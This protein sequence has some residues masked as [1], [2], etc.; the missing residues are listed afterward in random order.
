MGK[1]SLIPGMEAFMEDTS[2]EVDVE[3]GDGAEVVEEQTEAVEEEATVAEETTEAESDTEQAEMIFQQYDRIANY[4]DHAKK[5][6]VD[7]TFLSL[8]NSDGSLSQ[9]IGYSLPACESFD[10]TGSPMSAESQAVIAGLE[11]VFQSIWNFIKKIARKIRDFFSNVWNAIISRFGDID[12]QIGRLKVAK[13][14]RTWSND[15]AS[16]FKGDIFTSEDYKK[17]KAKLD[18]YDRNEYVAE[19]YGFLKNVAVGNVVGADRPGLPQKAYSVQTKDKGTFSDTYANGGKAKDVIKKA[20]ELIRDAKKEC[21]MS[22]VSNV[23]ETM[24]NDMLTYAENL[25]R[26]IL[27]EER[28]KKIFETASKTLEDLARK[29]ERHSGEPADANGPA[30]Q[31]RKAASIVNEAFGV[32]AKA[33]SVKT[34]SVRLLLASASKLINGCMRREGEERE[35]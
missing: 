24:C 32:L 25:R 1:Y 29:Y 35:L 4:L 17:V 6:G 8:L 3:V 20:N 21:K 18:E 26:Y 7:R 9:A 28:R 11:N 22:S 15:K 30:A 34:K 2:V 14:K 27:A 12:K 13:S 23:T 33:L 31:I 5:Y 10:V 19:A 16:D